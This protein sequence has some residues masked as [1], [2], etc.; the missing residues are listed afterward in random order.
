MTDAKPFP[1]KARD[2]VA[3]GHEIERALAART[4]WGM[5]VVL[6]RQTNGSVAALA[7]A[8]WR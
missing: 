3:W 5:Q 1:P 2:V 7:D 6:Y 4:I 8:C